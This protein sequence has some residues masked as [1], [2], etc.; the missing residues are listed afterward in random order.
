[1][2]VSFFVHLVTAWIFLLTCCSRPSERRSKT[3][4]RR[5]GLS[6]AKAAQILTDHFF[7]AWGLPPGEHNTKAA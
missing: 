1:M 7:G 4:W 3:F 2:H 5:S 6:I